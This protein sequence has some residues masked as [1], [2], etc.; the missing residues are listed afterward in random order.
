MNIIAIL[1]ATAFAFLSAYFVYFGIKHC[2]EYARMFPA[3][4]CAEM[5]T[6]PKS[7]PSAGGIL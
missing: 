1:L 3:G 5:P 7:F 4:Q 2:F 6:T